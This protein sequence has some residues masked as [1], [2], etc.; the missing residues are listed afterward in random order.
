MDEVENNINDLK[1]Q[2]KIIDELLFSNDFEEKLKLQIKKF[3]KYFS[4]ISNELY[5]KKYALK[6]DKVINKQEFYK[7]SSFNANMS[8]GKKQGEILCFDLAYILFAE[9]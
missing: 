3:N 6:Y 5:G 8:S 9:E 2:L 4:A 1:Q 7:F